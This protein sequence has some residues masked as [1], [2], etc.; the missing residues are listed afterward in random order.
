V[1]HLIDITSVVERDTFS[2][3]GKVYELRGMEELGPLHYERLVKLSEKHTKFE[4]LKRDLTASEKAQVSKALGEILKM[5]AVDLDQRS[6]AKIEPIQ[7][8]KVV[9]AWVDGY[10]EA[11]AAEGEAPAAPTTGGSSRASKRSTAATRKA[12]STSRA[13]R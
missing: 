2:V 6:L 3:D 4:K 8:A 1:T 13:T 5:I 12:G 7:R 9:N 11:G 10:L